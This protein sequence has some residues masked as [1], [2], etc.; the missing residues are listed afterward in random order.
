MKNDVYQLLP[1]SI[2]K[3]PNGSYPVFLETDDYVRNYERIS[4]DHLLA[5]EKDGVNPFMAEDYWRK[6]EEIT[7]GLVRKFTPQGGVLL[8]VGCGMGRLLAILSG[9]QRYGMDISAAYLSYAIKVGAEVCLAKVEDMPYKDELFDTV[10]CTDVLEHVLDLNA[11]VSQLFRVVK[12]GGYLVIRVPYRE[13]L[14]P[15]L[16]PE[17]PY[18]MAHLRNF[19]EFS[20]RMLFEKIFK[21]SVV[22]EVRG[23]YLEVGD[24]FKWPVKFRGL[25][26][27]VRNALRICSLFSENFKQRLVRIIFRPVEISFAIRKL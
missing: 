25:G 18:D 8:D 17:Y 22:S 1:K 5:F 23:P 7:A 10:V 4:A 20:L 19:D 2:L 16:R 21:G 9:Y 3:G 15:Y 13:N 27:A 14:E 24:Y 11:A 26:F 6:G 12:P